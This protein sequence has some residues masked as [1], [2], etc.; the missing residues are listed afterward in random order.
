MV[1]QIEND[2][3]VEKCIR[4]VGAVFESMAAADGPEPEEVGNRKGIHLVV[5]TDEQFEGAVGLEFEHGLH[6]KH[7]LEAVGRQIGLGYDYEK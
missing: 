2:R 3:A 6:R 1:R 4:E 5:A 7:S